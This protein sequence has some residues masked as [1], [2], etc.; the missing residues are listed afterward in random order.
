MSL[1]LCTQVAGNG[2]VFGAYTP[3]KWPHDAA[4]L[5]AFVHDPSDCT[6]LFSLVNAQ[7]R[8]VKLR[9]KPDKGYSVNLDGPSSGP[10]FGDTD[11]RLMAGSAA[12]EPHGCVVA[13]SHSF[14]LDHEAERAA[15]LPPIPFEYD[16]KL[17]AG[18]D[19]KGESIVAFGAAE[20]EV[21]Q[22]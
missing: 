7:G 11:L 18:D 4:A 5:C 2:F 12:D 20:I 21:Y 14:Q 1:C 22:L 19:G 17:L 16:Q 15:G 8:A 10:G 13:G 6:F 9:S 3:V